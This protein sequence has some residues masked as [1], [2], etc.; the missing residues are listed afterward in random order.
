MRF[1]KT[2]GTQVAGRFR[3][4]RERIAETVWDLRLACDGAVSLGERTAGSEQ[5]HWFGAL[6]RACSVFLRK[7]VIGDWND[8]S[9][10]LLDD[11]VLDEFGM[12]F[13]K[14]KR[15]TGPRRTVELV[16][17]IA[18]GMVQA[19]KLD[20]VTGLTEATVLLP[21]P[22][23]RLRI[24][25]EWPLAGTASWREAPT[26][27]FPWTIA[28]RELFEWAEG[29]QQLD[30]NGWLAQQLVMFDHRGITLK[31][32]IRT[33]AT[34]EGAHSINV[35]RLLQA[36]DKEDKGPF[37]HPE[38]HI[39]QNVTIL[40]VKYTHMVVV[41][42]ALY[43]WERLVDDGHVERPADDEWRLRP[44]LWMVDGAELFS[45]QQD[46]LR[47]AGGL[48]VA[49]GSEERSFEHRIRAVGK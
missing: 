25:V 4:K 6:A 33:V 16:K 15:V 1:V 12:G 35:S 40:G 10:R 30:C 17:E 13:D 23:H 34:Y 26:R 39:L 29:K 2:K 44:S 24:E 37:L 21:I 8:A 3:D 9:T 46:W 5:G 22:R 49:F 42:S 31:D 45:G 14:V 38:R 43:I 47:F 20:E 18:G 41:E 19:N 32:V 27:E 7:M 48:I 28:P 36:E 11:D